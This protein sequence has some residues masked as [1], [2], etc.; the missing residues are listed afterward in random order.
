VGG[1]R[2]GVNKSLR[3]FSAPGFRVLAG[4]LFHASCWCYVLLLCCRNGLGAWTKKKTVWTSAVPASGANLVI[5]NQSS[6][7]SAP[8]GTQSSETTASADGSLLSMVTE[9]SAGVPRQLHISDGEQ[10]YSV[11]FDNETSP[12]RTEVGIDGMDQE[13]LLMDVTTSFS[14]MGIR[15]KFFSFIFVL[16]FSRYPR[17]S[18]EVPPCCSR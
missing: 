15:L 6:E 11:T 3:M 16:F 8:Y 10:D 4:R 1:G 2:C 14:E 5:R 7:S 9:S 17:I 18:T 12:G 13:N